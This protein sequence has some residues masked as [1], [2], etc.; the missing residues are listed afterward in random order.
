MIIRRPAFVAMLFALLAVAGCTTT[1]PRY[2][3]MSPV[4]PAETAPATQ[5]LTLG[6]GP[7]QLADYLQRANLVTRTSSSRIHVA[8]HDKWGA[9]LD[10]HVS[11]ILAE[12]LRL[13]LGL[14][15]VQVY[16]WQ[17]GVRIDI[18]VTAEITRFI[19]D[20]DTV[21][22]DARW[23]A[24]GPGLDGVMEGSSRIAETSG[25]DYDEIVDAMSRATGRLADDIATALRR[26]SKQS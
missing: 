12:D 11:E 15:G 18:Q 25:P 1:Q 9:T 20:G 6:V 16:P 5:R 2:Y 23:L 26:R 24:R 21:Y 10:T 22:L 3:L 19:L 14:S 8:T 7:V 17:P 13:R 4:T